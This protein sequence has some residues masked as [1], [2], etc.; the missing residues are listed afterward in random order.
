MNITAPWT[1]DQVNSLNG[2]QRMAWGHP[3]TCGN[4]CRVEG[5]PLV[6][7]V[8]GWIC[9]YCDYTQNW[10]HEFMADSSWK[11]GNTLAE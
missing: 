2:Y 10:A 4:G 11:Y 7:T 5:Q 1:A 8:H 3:F 6:A 9:V